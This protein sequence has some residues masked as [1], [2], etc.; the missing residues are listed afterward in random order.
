MIGKLKLQQNIYDDLSNY[1][2]YI[3]KNSYDYSINIYT[4]LSTSFENLISKHEYLNKNIDESLEFAMSSEDREQYMKYQNKGY[5]LLHN[6]T[7]ISFD[8]DL[9]QVKKYI[10]LNP[11]LKSKKILFEVKNLDELIIQDF[12]NVFGANTENIYIELENKFGVTSF[13]EY[14][15][16]VNTFNLLVSEIESHNFS[17]MENIMYVYDIVR[18]RE[19]KK[20]YDD[21]KTKSRSL[22]SVLLG[23]EIVCAGY[24]SLFNSLLT[25][26]GIATNDFVL[27]GKNNNPEGH[28]FSEIYVKD[29]KYGIDG[30]YYFDP[31][32]DSKTSKDSN[33]HFQSFKFF[34]LTREKIKSIYDKYFDYDDFPYY[35]NNMVK[36]CEILLDTKSY[37]NVDKNILKSI[38]HMSHIVANKTLIEPVLWFH[39]PSDVAA[40]GRDKNE[41]L[42]KFK[43]IEEH[44]NKQL[45]ADTLLKVLFNVRKVEY[46]A[47]PEKFKFELAAFYDVLM[48]SD[49]KFKLSDFENEFFSHFQSD[50]IYINQLTKK[51]FLEYDKHNNLEKNIEQVKLVRTLK[52][53]SDK[54]STKNKVL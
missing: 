47:Y 37:E 33:S 2:F 14:K 50:P 42:E 15:K 38:N 17:P 53:I 31:T 49:W 52:Q 28:V 45:S 16:M 32:W 46:Y 39:I 11:I 22:F 35:S 29:K 13:N 19:Y 26:L 34:A 41:I 20:S 21:D 8:F 6:A 9:E 7:Y 51:Y 36:D 40:P 4:D 30:V 24:T 25:K 23:D 5:E 18:D 1:D 12:E 48:C 44:F 43:G 27:S 10:E 3:T 54:E